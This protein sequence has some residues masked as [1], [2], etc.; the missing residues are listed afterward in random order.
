MIS[1]FI[2]INKYKI[3]TSFIS[4]KGPNPRAIKT[5][6]NFMIFILIFLEIVFNTMLRTGR[7][8]V[9]INWVRSHTLIFISH[10]SSILNPDVIIQTKY[11]L[12]NSVI[13]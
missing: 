5:V 12:Y 1:A 4:P 3:K 9:D 8:S 10:C 13:P 2:N 7:N 6:I 11:L